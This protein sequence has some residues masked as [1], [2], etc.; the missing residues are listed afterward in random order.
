MSSENYPFLSATATGGTVPL[1]GLDTDALIRDNAIPD[2]GARWGAIR[3]DVI[4]ITDG[5]QPTIV[6]AFNADPAGPYEM[7]G[8]LTTFTTFRGM[9]YALTME[10]GLWG[11]FPGTPAAGIHFKFLAD[12]SGSASG[13]PPGG[14]EFDIL[15]KQSAID[16]DVLWLPG[17]DGG[18]YL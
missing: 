13:L 1:G 5:G 16:G 10:T 11:A 4:D 8:D 2:T 12:V 18:L 9:I 7:R 3:A 14:V 15:V 6:D 17:L